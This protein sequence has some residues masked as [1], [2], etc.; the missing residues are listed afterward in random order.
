MTTTLICVI[1]DDAAVRKSV[2]AVLESAGFRVREFESA[3]SF[4]TLCPER[5]ACLITDV[6]MPEMDG[7]E[8]LAEINKLGIN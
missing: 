4:L 8:L 7:L 6:R 3:R 5:S 1:D 2:R